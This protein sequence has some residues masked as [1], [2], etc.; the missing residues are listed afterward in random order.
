MTDREAVA[1][2]E[3]AEQE[4]AILIHTF[5]N[6]TL[7][8]QALNSSVSN[9]PFIAKRPAIAYDANLRLN[10]YFQTASGDTWDKWDETDIRTRGEELFK[11]ALEIWPKPVN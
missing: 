5:G 8:T 10:V 1:A 11:T 9:G 2:Q 4:R 7:L 3:K 6:L